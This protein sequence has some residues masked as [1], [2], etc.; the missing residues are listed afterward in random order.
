[1][2]KTRWPDIAA[3][4]NRH[5]RWLYR[6]GRPNRLARLEN[7]ISHTLFGLGLV[8]PN[9]MAE[10]RVPGRRTGRLISFPVVVADHGGE[11]YLVAMLGEN[12]NWVRNVRAAGGRAELRHGRREHVLLREVA[13]E[14][15]APILRAYLDVAPGARPHIPV[16]RSAPLTEFERVAPRI[17]VF[18]VTADSSAGAPR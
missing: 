13:P 16:D 3:W 12:A 1:M 15:R 2:D 6:G 14:D 10:L 8:M 5:H 17:P 7:R 9:R 4:W 18:R 11:R